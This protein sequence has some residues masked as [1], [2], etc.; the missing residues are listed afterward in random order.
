M[1][2]F[3]W[4][5]QKITLIDT[6]G[7]REKNKITDKIEKLSVKATLDTV[8]YAQIIVLVLDSNEIIS[9]QDLNIASHIIEEGRVLVIAANKWDILKIKEEVKLNF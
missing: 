4:K 8:K 9:K 3:L 7:L 2:D 1:L 6:A 5:D